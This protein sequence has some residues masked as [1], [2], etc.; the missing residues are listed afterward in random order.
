MKVKELCKEFFK[1]LKEYVAYLMKVDF[2]ELFVNTVILICILA[3]ATFVYLPVSLVDDLILSLLTIFIQFSATLAAIYHWIF[4]LISFVLSVLAF[5]YLFNMRF[6]D[7]KEKG[8]E[9]K[10]E[11]KPKNGDAPKTELDLPKKK[12]D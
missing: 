6:K 8:L 12:E 3:L 10:V 2:K 9:N 4:K 11:I 5:M 7:V 1:N